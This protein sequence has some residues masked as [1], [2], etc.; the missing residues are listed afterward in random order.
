MPKT[1]TNTHNCGP[2]VHDEAT[3]FVLLDSDLSTKGQK[4]RRTHRVPLRGTRRL[5]R[6]TRWAPTACRRRARACRRRS[7]TAGTCL[8]RSS[9]PCCAKWWT[10][11]PGCPRSQRGRWGCWRS[12]RAR[13]CSLES[14]T[15]CTRFGWLDIA[16]LAGCCC[17][18]RCYP[19]PGA[20]FRSDFV[21][22]ATDCS[23]SPVMPW[24]DKF[25]RLAGQPI[26]FWFSDVERSHPLYRHSTCRWLFVLRMDFQSGFNKQNEKHSCSLWFSL[27]TDAVHQVFFSPISKLMMFFNSTPIVLWWNETKHSCFCS[28]WRKKF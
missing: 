23:S 1:R 13:T 3:L 22:P 6:R 15:G 7:A 17:C 16:S 26:A 21:A 27:K 28:F 10:W 18:L 4:R 12:S 9:C 20:R 11:R 5:C 14:G 19:N 24:C 25:R 2:A 8:S